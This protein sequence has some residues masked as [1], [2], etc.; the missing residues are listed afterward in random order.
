MTELL[1]VGRPELAAPEA[2]RLVADT[3]PTL[4]EQVFDVTM[5]QVEA[6]V[7]PDGVADDFRWEAMTAVQGGVD[8]H[9]PI[10]PDAAALN[11][12]APVTMLTAWL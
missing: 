10:L 3:N 8:R 1:G 9:G 5:A 7:Q 2:D 12:S 11:L 6:E 4:G